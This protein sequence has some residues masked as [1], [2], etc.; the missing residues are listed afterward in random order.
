LFLTF[1]RVPPGTDGGVTLVGTLAGL[2][3]AIVVALVGS[4]I[5]GGNSIFALVSVAGA[6]MGL[7]FDSFLGATLERKG[8]LNND[9]VNFLSTS[10]ATI[11]SLLALFVSEMAS[12][13]GPF[14]NVQI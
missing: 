11:F 2:G 6:G 8:W 1:R 4:W 12:A 14:S 7:F 3:A 13:H 9:A 5:F 10:S